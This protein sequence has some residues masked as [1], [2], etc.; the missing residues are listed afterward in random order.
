MADKKRVIAL[1]FFDGVHIGHAKLMEMT[2]RR[3]LELD[4]VPTVLS[5]D[6]HP[7][8]LVKGVE[9]P[10]INAP[11]GRADIIRRIYGIDSVIFIHF[12]R[13]VMCMPWQ[14]FIESLCTEL[15]ACHFVVGYDFS[16]GYRGEGRPDKLCA[17]CAERSLGC[18]VIPAVTL[19]GEVVS[20]T[21]IRRLI[22][23][24]DMDE[25]NRLLGH[26]HSLIDTVHYGYQLGVKLGAPTINM[27]FND[28]VL[29]PR[30]GV[31]ATRVF[32]END[33]Q[34][35]AVT[36]VGVR[37]TVSGGDRV[38]VESFILGF[39]GDLYDRRV[40]VE[41][42]HFL[43]DERKFPGVEELRAQIARDA[44]ATEAYFASAEREE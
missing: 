18:D 28:G 41:F 7:D 3:A 29:V 39:D 43:R 12:N 19:D 31:Y 4:A 24:G 20:S 38:S 35:I 10:L 2:K 5:F 21:R 34:Y 33:G 1:G 11:E 13:D 9:V 30:H 17:Y 8:T 15:N 22:A 42:H 37:P 16:F 14:D 26:P 44:A 36:N 6:L 25:A 23:D 32:P 27:Q 40:R